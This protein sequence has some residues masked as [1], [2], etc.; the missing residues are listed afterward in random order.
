MIN[1][2]KKNKDYKLIIYGNGSM[3]EELEEY[4]FG[5]ALQILYNELQKVL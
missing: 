5:E 3:R 4:A 2:Y 1:I